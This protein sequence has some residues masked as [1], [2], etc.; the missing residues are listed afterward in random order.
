LRAAKGRARVPAG[1]AGG[2]LRLQWPV[3]RREVAETA[4]VLPAG[5]LGSSRFRFVSPSGVVEAEA[6]A[7]PWNKSSRSLPSLVGVP[8]RR[9]RRGRGGG[10][11]FHRL[12]LR[13]LRRLLLCRCGGVAVLV[14]RSCLGAEVAVGAVDG[15]RAGRL[16]L[17]FGSG[18]WRASIRDLRSLGRVPGRRSFNGVF[19]PAF[20]LGIYCGSL[21]PVGD[22]ASS[23]R[24]RWRWRRQRRLRLRPTVRL[25]GKGSRDL[26]AISVFVV[27]LFAKCGGQLTPVS[28]MYLY[29]YR[30][31]MFSLSLNTGT[32]DKKN[33]LPSWCRKLWHRRGTAREN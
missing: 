23:D 21:K 30:P 5:R 31:C 7:A 25:D 2:L 26:F 20:V 29:L 32:F 28:R 17:P 16:R 24:G 6:T 13:S 11:R 33:V 27:A 8:L 4:G 19:V 22:G 3:G 12:L 10:V 18:R 1:G 15:G 9:R 14:P